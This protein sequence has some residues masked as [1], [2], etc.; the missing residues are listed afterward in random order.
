MPRCDSELAVRV[1]EMHLD[2]LRRDVETLCNIAVCLALGG[3]T[4]DSSLA[5]SQGAHPAESSR[6]RAGTRRVDLRPD[7]IDKW[8]RT[9]H[10]RELERAAQ[11]LA[12]LGRLARSTQRGPERGERLCLLE[13]RW[14]LLE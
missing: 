2:C 9:A 1:A 7:R 13:P 3:E 11:R 10:V 8:L 12:G 4:R 5:R 6:A 14:H